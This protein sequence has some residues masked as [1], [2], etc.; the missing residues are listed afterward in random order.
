MKEIP[1]KPLLKTITFDRLLNAALAILSFLL[2]ALTKKNF[3]WGQ[4][5][6]L[7]VEPTNFCN[8]KCP[9]CITGN[10]KMTRTAGIM[11]F[12]R[13]RKL[14]DSA[15][16]RIF[17]L[18]L[19]QQ[20]EPY[21]NKEFINFIRYAKKK[22]IFVTTSTNAHYLDKETARQ[23]VASGLD[24]IIVSI[25]GADQLNYETYRVRGELAKVKQGVENLVREKRKQKSETPFI[26]IQFIVM[27][28]NEHQIPEMQ[29]L[30]KELGANKLLKKTV[31]VETV[32]EAV[33]WLPGNESFRRYDFK[34]NRLIPKRVVNGPC[35]RPWTSSL[36]NWDGSVVP[37]CFDKNAQHIT[38]SVGET[39]FNKI[40]DS[41]KYADFRTKILNDRGSLDICSNCSKGLRLYF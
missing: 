15:G 39:G 9:L 34:R 33:Q 3:V 40:W 41:E 35:P 14:L 16:D 36:V 2:S 23:T 10:G 6:L 5:F 29:K 19:Y 22:R 20:G 27:R 26:Y 25:D 17:Y 31:H 30:T 21:I 12:A 38:G 8:L 7:T 32:E 24:S 37:C 1:L 18:L 4:P 11:D 28:H 13:F